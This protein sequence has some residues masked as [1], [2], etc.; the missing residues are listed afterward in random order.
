MLSRVKLCHLHPLLR[1]SRYVGPR[2]SGGPTYRNLVGNDEIVAALSVIV[3]RSPLSGPH[4]VGDDVRE[5]GDD[6]KGT[7]SGTNS[8]R[9]HFRRLSR[10]L[11]PGL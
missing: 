7:E 8:S 3:A 10:H 5:D 4:A 2:E 6:I 9:C 11:L 1:H